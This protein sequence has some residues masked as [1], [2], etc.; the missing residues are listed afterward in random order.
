MRIPVVTALAILLVGLLVSCEREV[1]DETVTG[2]WGVASDGLSLRLIS[3]TDR[4]PMGAGVELDLEFRRAAA[5]SDT[6]PLILNTA[7]GSWSV[8]V[9]F[10]NEATGEV[11]ERPPYDVGMPHPSARPEDHQELTGDGS[12]GFGI[13]VH[14]LSHSGE[15][16]P[17][18]DYVVTAR[19]APDE[20]Q[21][22]T[23]ARRR[24]FGL[25]APRPA[26]S[27]PAWHGTVRSGPLRLKVLPAAEEERE[28][29]INSSLKIWADPD[30]GGLAYCWSEED[31]LRLK[32]THRPGYALG[33]EYRMSWYLAGELVTISPPV[34]SLSSSLFGVTTGG[35]RGR[36]FLECNPHRLGTRRSDFIR[37][38]GSLRIVA[39][40]EVF[41]TSA[42]GGHL[43]YP[44]GGD[45]KVLW[46]GQIEGSWP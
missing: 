7:W 14:L 32:V 36:L 21:E 31:P 12:R 2:E 5:A 20:D 40:V 45:Y 46:K 43:W 44:Q 38:A 25:D 41:E 16:I 13:I 30:H 24:E 3:E 19:C 37:E 35:Q 28:L 26:E 39:D 42:Q 18:G 6:I 29:K 8:R 9:E 10:L 23:Y 33:L 27:R 15:Q 1:T 11:Y 4:V 34:D 17:P 22:T